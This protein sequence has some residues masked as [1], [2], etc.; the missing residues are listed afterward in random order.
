M[1]EVGGIERLAVR[2]M[3]TRPLS[4]QSAPAACRF[5]LLPFLV[6]LEGV[7]ALCL[8]DDRPFGGEV[9]VCGTVRHRVRVRC[10]D[11]G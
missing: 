5:F 11:R 6:T 2:V 9:L 3:K 10:R 7:D 4:V 8:E 1:G